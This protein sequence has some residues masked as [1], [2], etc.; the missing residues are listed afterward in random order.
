M[1]ASSMPPFAH[2]LVDAAGVTIHCAEVP[3]QG[4]AMLMLHGIGMD[5]R[6]WQ[7]VSRRLHPHFRLFLMDLR[8][9][10]RSAKPKEGYSVAHYAADVED[11]IDAL[12]LRG[13]VLLGSSLGGMVAAAVEAPEAL[14]SYR[15]LVDPPITGG[16]IRD[17]AGFREILRLKHE[18]PEALAEYLA[19]SNPGAGSHLVRSMSAM[20]HE[21]ADAVITEMLE[22]AD[23]YFAIDDAL[24]SVESPTLLMQ[25]D[26]SMHPA[27]TTDGAAHAL[28]L[29]PRGSL[30]TVAGAGHA[31]H[32]YRPRE[33]VR[34][35]ADFTADDGRSDAS[36]NIQT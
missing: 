6:V 33:F 8:G 21:A 4:R 15:I 18:P 11:V 2:R 26:P 9:H 7:A 17:A 12:G 25:A 24:R 32:G 28:D 35:I 5:W 27:L 36:Y 29:L 13:V 19:S 22:H 20:W 30:V 10:G 1:P 23:D 34:L 16:E 14:V 3:G 31:I